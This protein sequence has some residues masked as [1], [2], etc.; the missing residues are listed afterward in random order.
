MSRDNSA[1]GAEIE[2]N[3]DSFLLA[4]VRTDGFDEFGATLSGGA[5]GWSAEGVHNRTFDNFAFRGDPSGDGD[6]VFVE[7][8]GST[9]GSRYVEDV[10]ASW[11]GIS[12]DADGCD[13]PAMTSDG[14]GVFRLAMACG[15]GVRI[16]ERFAGTSGFTLVATLGTSVLNL[17]AIATNSGQYGVAANGASAQWAFDDYSGSW[18]SGRQYH[19]ETGSWGPSI[20]WDGDYFHAVWVEGIPGEVFAKRHP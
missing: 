1:V 19:D 17:P 7:S 15:D 8:D 6:Y 12:I 18:S 14:D 11:Y 9:V 4:G 10:L 2:S 13:H 20:T 5:W 3:G 16:Y